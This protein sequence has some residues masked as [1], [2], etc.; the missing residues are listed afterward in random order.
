MSAALAGGFV[1]AYLLKLGF[2]LPMALLAYAALLTLRF[3]LRFVALAAVRRLGY[4]G[5]MATGAALAATQFLPLLWAEDPVWLGIWLLVVSLAE[6]LYWPVYHAAVAVTGGQSR[7]RELGI[8]TAVGALVGVL[9]PLA[10]GFLLERFG[11]EVDFAIAAALSLAAVLPLLALPGIPAGPVPT[12]RDSVRAVDRA[13]IA[14]FAADGWMASGLA[15]A[16]P[17]VLFITLDFRYESFGIANAAA[18]LVGAAAGLV[19]G[20]AIDRGQR[21]RY[22]LLVCAALALGF[23]L[24]ACATWS[25][26]A[27]TVA[28]ATGAAVH[29]LYVPVLMSVVYD[30]AK[31]SGSAFRFHFSAEAGW[32]VGAILGCLAAAAVA[33]ATVTPSLALLPAALGVVAVHA[34]VRGQAVPAARLP[35]GETV[36]AG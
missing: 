30:R 23:A 15:L 14:A 12:L 25:P 1:G 22:L 21:D 29:G 27:A 26:L 31:E 35:L 16:W 28:N 36:P 3:G 10:G 4:R 2:S 7:G 8:R 18:G 20:R 11:P 9:G 32:D 13:G 33:W 17:M 5:A 24:R 34:C 19:C 6:S